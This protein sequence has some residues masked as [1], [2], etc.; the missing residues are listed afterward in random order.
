M[1][2]KKLK[3]M[4]KLAPSSDQAIL[5]V[6]RIFSAPIENVF[7]AWTKPEVLASWFGSAGFIATTANIDLR[8][9]GKYLLVLQPPEGESI[10]HFGEYLEITPP[11]KLVFTWVLENQ[12]C[13]GSKNQ[14]AETLVSI[15][16]K[17]IN[18]STKIRLTHERLPSKE[19]YQGHEFGWNCAFDCFGKYILAKE[20]FGF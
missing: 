9:G 12:A 5:T 7:E 14:C 1:T 17:P 19:A 16:F 15:D 10:K 4:D 2:V 11:Q 8:V 18:Q 3:K 13:G 20:S 6:S